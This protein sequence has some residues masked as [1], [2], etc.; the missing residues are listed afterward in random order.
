MNRK[1]LLFICLVT[2]GMGAVCGEEHYRPFGL[3]FGLTKAEIEKSWVVPE[4]FAVSANGHGPYYDIPGIRD[5]FPD[6]P[7]GKLSLYFGRKLGRLWRVLWT[8]PDLI[9]ADRQTVTERILAHLKGEGFGETLADKE[10]GNYLLKRGD[11]LANLVSNP[12]GSSGTGVAFFSSDFRSQWLR[13]KLTDDR[14]WIQDKLSKGSCEVYPGMTVNYPYFSLD[15]KSGDCLLRSSRVILKTTGEKLE[16]ELAF[17]LRGVEFN[18]EEICAL[19]KGIIR[20]TFK[21]KP[22][23]LKTRLSGK[24]DAGKEVTVICVD[25]SPINDAYLTLAILDFFQSM[26]VS[27]DYDVY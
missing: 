26:L 17:N 4:N 3:E 18:I 22:G 25:I 20:L 19:E 24:Q 8:I 13:E 23:F 2:F 6:C 1:H 7:T 27:G 15:P 9:A 11:V 21:E 16:E 5:Y 12:G 10:A 14:Q